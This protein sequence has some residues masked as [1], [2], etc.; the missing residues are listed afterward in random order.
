MATPSRLFGAIHVKCSVQLSTVVLVRS[1]TD[2]SRP[3][4]TCDVTYNDQVLLP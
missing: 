2:D 4:D 1:L 3:I